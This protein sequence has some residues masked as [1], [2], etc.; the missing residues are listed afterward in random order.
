MCQVVLEESKEGRSWRSNSRRATKVEIVWDD[1]A[2]DA[3][4]VD[5]G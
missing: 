1:S 2:I 3:K 4:L 5:D